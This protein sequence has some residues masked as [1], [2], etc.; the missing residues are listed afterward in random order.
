MSV[1]RPFR[2]RE[3]SRHV[4][5]SVIKLDRATRSVSE[6]KILFDLCQPL[7]ALS[8]DGQEDEIVE[9]ASRIAR[10][11][12]TIRNDNNEEVLNMFKY[13]LKSV[14]SGGE[15]TMQAVIPVLCFLGLKETKKLLMQQ[16]EKEYGQHEH[17]IT[18]PMRDQ[19][20][21]SKIIREWYDF[22]FQAAMKLPESNA[23]YAP[24]TIQLLLMLA[25]SAS[26]DANSLDMALE[27][28]EQ[29]FFLFEECIS[30]SK[31]EVRALHCIMGVLNRCLVFDDDSRS[32]L[33]RKTVASCSQLLRRSDQCLAALACAHMYW[34]ENGNDI[35]HTTKFTKPSASADVDV[36]NWRQNEEDVERP[37]CV[38]V[39]HSKQKDVMQNEPV[40]DP[41]QVLAC[42]KRAL[43]IAHSAR[44]Y[45]NAG[46]AHVRRG[47]TPSSPGLLFIDI[48]NA[49][50]DWYSKD[51]PG[52]DIDDVQNALDLAGNEVNSDLCRNDNEIACFW[53]NTKSRVECLIQYEQQ[54][55][56]YSA[57]AMDKFAKLEL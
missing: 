51:L 8:D 44:Q 42:L 22:M 14:M 45:C 30:D 50:L 3:I 57:N 31:E 55:V 2:R 6:T 16:Q 56:K 40:Q 46:I 36:E 5:N 4:I 10:L 18:V 37:A 29:V 49:Y 15:R 48:A 54:E 28:T 32:K 19:L 7:V 33:V 24:M 47:D 53:K 9:D 39:D 12:H 38:E 43:R 20:K 25:A 35:E 34:Q 21:E 27:C 17:S 11:V 1:L 23:S 13:V 26:Q 52:I 41:M